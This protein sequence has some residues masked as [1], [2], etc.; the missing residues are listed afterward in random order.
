[1]FV[2]C[3]FVFV[4]TWILHLTSLDRSDYVEF[5]IHRNPR[6]IIRTERNGR[7]TF[8]IKEVAISRIVSPSIAHRD[9]IFYILVVYN[10]GVAFD[11][12][13]RVVEL[14]ISTCDLEAA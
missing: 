9:R 8:L 4:V 1:V 13:L 7:E 3:S 10:Y 5:L 14:L 11:V 12:S 2:V 6:P